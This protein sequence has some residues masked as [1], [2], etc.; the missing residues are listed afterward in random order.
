MAAKKQVY[1]IIFKGQ[2]PVWKVFNENGFSDCEEPDIKDRCPVVALLPDPLVFFFKPKG[3][4]KSRHAKS[5]TLMQMSYSLPGNDGG[6]FK[7]LR[8]AGNAVLGYTGHDLLSHFME[9]NR[10]ILSR[11]T[12]ITTSF[13]VCW[14]AALAEG[15]SVWSWKG[16]GGMR[17][18]FTPDFFCYFKGTDQELKERYE[19]IGLDA[20]PELIDLEKACSIFFDK[21]IRWSR[22][23]LVTTVTGSTDKASVVDYKPFVKA[24][25]L[26]TLVGLFFIAGQYHRLQAKEDQ[27]DLW[28][29]N[30]RQLY[31]SALGPSPGGDPYG[32][33]LYK[34]D[35]LKN[36]GTVKGVDVLGLLSTLSESAPVGMTVDSMNLGS[37]SGNIRG[38]LSTYDELDKM[39]EKLA[40]NGRFKFVLEQADNVDNG[41][42]F[43]LRAEYNR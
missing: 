43:S 14:R 24:A 32:T 29:K 20:E 31:I 35:Q 23:G 3:V 30:L 6:A 21:K 28:R 1:I 40:A 9:R 34:L 2:E 12:V 18:L 17:A 22:I 39:M 33:I 36:G 8:P 38:T 25:I 27:A 16:Q 5:A 19:N 13:A 15:L 10:D 41:I 26:V 7:V 37:D 42:S 4:D 11:A